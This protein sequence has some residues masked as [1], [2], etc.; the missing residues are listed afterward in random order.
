M[1]GLPAL[2][3][4]S[5]EAVP[6]S[7]HSMWFRTLTVLHVSLPLFFPSSFYSEASSMYDVFLRALASI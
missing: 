7:A 5:S 6:Q 3:G 1:E 4:V 2:L